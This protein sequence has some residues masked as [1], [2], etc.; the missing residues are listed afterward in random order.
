MKLKNRPW[1]MLTA[2]G[3]LATLLHW[4]VAHA[5]AAYRC[6]A[7]DGS[8]VYADMPCGANSQPQVLPTAPS[9]TKPALAP[10][11]VGPPN[12]VFNGNSRPPPL[13]E[14]ERQTQA[15]VCTTDKFNAYI[16]TL[17]RP[18]P[19]WDVRRL[20]Y[21]EIANDC[22]RSLQLPDVV[23]QPSPPVKPPLS[24][25]T[26]D[27]TAARFAQ[28][29]RSGSVDQIQAYLSTPGVDINERAG[30]V[31]DKALLDYAAEL[32][33]KAI[34]Q[35]LIDH[36]ALVDA[37]QKLGRNRGLT[38]LHRA[39]MN[40]SAEVAELLLDHGAQ[41]NYHGPLGAT[42]L[43]LAVSNNKARTVDVL[44]AHG[45]DIT[46]LANV[47]T[48]IGLQLQT[49]L[50]VAT[51]RGY[52][53]IANALAAHAAAP[54]K[55]ALTQA[56]MRADLDSVRLAM[57]HDELMHDIDTNSKN[58]ALRF[59]VIGLDNLESRKQV[60]DLLVAHGANVN[61]DQ[62]HASVTPVMLAS[63]P[64]S[65]QVLI[66]DGATLKVDGSYGP[67][68]QSLACNTL[69][70]DPSA[71]FTVLLAHGVDIAVIPKKGLNALECAV[72]LHRVDFE[73]FLL[74][75][76]V[77][78]DLRDSAGRTAVYLAGD[79]ATLAPLTQRGANVNVTDSHTDTPLS[80]ALADGK[81]AQARLLLDAGANARV[82]PQH[83]E[84]PLN[85]AAKAGHL[86]TVMALLAKGADIN[87]VNDYGDSALAGA[88]ELNPDAVAQYLI[89][90]G[91]NVNTR[92]RDGATPLHIAALHNNAALVALLLS[93][94]ADAA[95]LDNDHLRADRR[96]T[97]LPVRSLFGSSGANGTPS[98]KD[99]A[100]C[101]QV[102]AGPIPAGG[103]M[104]TSSIVAQDPSEDWRYYEQIADVR[105]IE[106]SHRKYLLGVNADGPVYLALIDSEGVEDL[107]CEF[108]SNH[109]IMSVY[110]RLTA[111]AQRDFQS[112]SLE[113]LKVVGV[114][115]AQ[116][117]LDAS[118]SREHP[119]PLGADSDGALLGD[120]ILARRDD[121]LRFYLDHGVDPDLGWVDHHPVDGTHAL[122][123]YDASI[124]TAA[125]RG[126]LDELRLLLEHSANPNGTGDV[127]H[128]PAI[129]WAVLNARM[130]VEQVL[131]QFGAD[132][133]IPPNT[134][135]I[136]QT[137]DN[138]SRSAVSVDDGLQAIHTLF[139]HGA[140][141]NP[142]I[143]I[144]F[145]NYAR[146]KRRDD[147][148]RWALNSKRGV[149]TEWIQSA[150]GT[151][152][153]ADATTE[154]LLRDALAFRDAAPCAANATAGELTTCLP[155]D[156]RATIGDLQFN[157]QQAQAWSKGLE[158]RC[159]LRPLSPHVTAAG[160]FSYVLSD[161]TRAVCVLKAA[162]ETH[163]T[164]RTAA[165]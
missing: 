130:E 60:I 113:S 35:W 103:V 55:Q 159:H 135:A 21:V 129:A 46:T 34:A 151:A 84:P 11:R 152:G 59:A 48:P 54:N 96:T 147:L 6:I 7:P 116:A 127:F 145:Q 42:P 120:V 65:L 143:F 133:N 66:A 162:Q 58:E 91:A 137:L 19:E 74:N 25:A 131:L 150:F 85:V 119:I 132:P 81:S 136:A 73:L 33:Q 29:T 27:A 158:R 72:H 44:L 36:G 39:A 22:R 17:P 109:R 88:L 126:S 108:G 3:A 62:E 164:K 155:N 114:A 99:L 24:G 49:A 4:M 14:N 57:K 15:L 112:T 52:T 8:T 78:A 107:V 161:Q 104:D 138:I 47:M 90:H 128:H 68:V 106:L 124:Y 122:R 100:A 92:R 20:K 43:I 2:L 77:P 32:N 64:E 118:Q 160:W 30:S 134:Y 18:L 149:K 70:N 101:A 144:A 37:S 69:I 28:L 110:E 38:P 79:P 80:T 86:R 63:T 71:V 9:R 10:P 115:G 141:P 154:S 87:A 75:H 111:R 105:P 61:G 31:D 125:Q 1:M 142:W 156:L 94:H 165:R 97:S 16:R 157:D 50:T 83:G 23:V 123:W 5:G 163:F 98:P 139:V 148:L 93:R 121:V 26:G 146:A 95:A 53:G 140:D 102:L 56:A 82:A 41:I 89:E 45:A 40:D 76:G 153:P 51:E 67:V 12:S 13:S 117:L